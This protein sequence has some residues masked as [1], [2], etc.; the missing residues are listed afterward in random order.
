MGPILGASFA[1]LAD[2]AYAIID[3]LNTPK[4]RRGLDSRKLNVLLAT[5]SRPRRVRARREGAA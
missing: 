3:A 5:V 2:E 1:A 4:K